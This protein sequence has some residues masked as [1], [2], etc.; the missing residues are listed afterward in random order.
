VPSDTLSVASGMARV[1][2]SGI[3]QALRRSAAP[4][5][6]LDSQFRLMYCNPAW[7]RFAK[8]NGALQFTSKAL[9][10]CNLLDALPDS[11]KAFY[12]DAFRQALSAGPVWEHSYECSS[13]TSSRKF[14]M[15]I[16][17]LKPQDWFVVTNTLIVER[18]PGGTAAAGPHKYVDANG[19]VTICAHCSCSRR[20]QS[21]DQWDFVTEYLCPKRESAVR[22]SHGLCPVCRAYFYRLN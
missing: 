21:R 6:I 18:S 11:L 17:L 20:V 16:H 19:L 7:N 2:L 10:G 1:H 22:V 3:M 9:V 13:P 5:N 8:S 4:S 12:L 15:R 14:R